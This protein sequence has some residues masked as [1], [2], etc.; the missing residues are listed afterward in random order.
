MGDTKFAIRDILEEEVD[1]KYTLSDKLW[2]YLQEYAKNTK[3][4]VTVLVLD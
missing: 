1:P 4:K 2:N 3:R